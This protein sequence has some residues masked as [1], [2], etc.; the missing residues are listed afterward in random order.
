MNDILKKK[1]ISNLTEAKTVLQNVKKKKKLS[2]KL[3]QNSSH[4]AAE[5][6]MDEM[7]CFVFH[8]P[9]DQM[10]SELKMRYSQ[11]TLKV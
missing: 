4:Y 5:N 2:S 1:Y 8:T 7:K 10:L 3:F 6:K 9:L 11:K